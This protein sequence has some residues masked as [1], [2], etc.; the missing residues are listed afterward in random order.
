MATDQKKDISGLVSGA[1]GKPFAIVGGLGNTFAQMMAARQAKK[2]EQ[3]YTGSMEELLAG[4]SADIEGLLGGDAYR[5]YLDTA[6]AQSMLE[7][8]RQQLQDYANQI[9]G[10]VARSGGTTESAV[11]SQTAGT[12]GY[13]DIVNRMA[14]HGTQYNQM[15]KSRLLGARQGLNRDK[16]QYATNLY[17][18]SQNKAEGISKQGQNFSNSMVGLGESYAADT[19]GIMKLLG[20]G[21]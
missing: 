13:A 15:A 4:Q 17:S 3:A 2:G 20:I 12:K 19:E 9:K 8:T 16:G 11:A 5:N 14:G 1:I 10:G 18:M 21:L 6:Q 7:T